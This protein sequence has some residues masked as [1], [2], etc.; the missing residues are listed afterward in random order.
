MGLVGWSAGA[1]NIPKLI[2]RSRACKSFL[3]NNLI[4]DGAAVNETDES[5]IGLQQS[6]IIALAPS[7]RTHNLGVGLLG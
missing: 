5:L 1:Y 7:D 6:Y 4:Y 2:A 3:G